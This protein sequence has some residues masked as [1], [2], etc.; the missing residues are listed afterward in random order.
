MRQRFVD[1]VLSHRLSPYDVVTPGLVAR[2]SWP[3]L[4]A[5]GPDARRLLAEL[6]DRARAEAVRQYRNRRRHYGELPRS[7]RRHDELSWSAEKRAALVD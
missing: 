6:R 5:G 4:R 7:S 1:D 3:V 2:A